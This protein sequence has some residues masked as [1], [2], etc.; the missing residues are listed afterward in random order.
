MLVHVTVDTCQDLADKY[1]GQLESKLTK[2]IKFNQQ[3]S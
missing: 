2:L 1:I 3:I